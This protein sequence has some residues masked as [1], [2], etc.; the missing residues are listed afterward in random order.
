MVFQ[1]NKIISVAYLYT[2][3]KIYKLINLKFGKLANGNSPI[4]AIERGELALFHF[5][6]GLI[7][8]F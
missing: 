8:L 3:K 7:I 4:I 2:F 1:D 5:P 6:I